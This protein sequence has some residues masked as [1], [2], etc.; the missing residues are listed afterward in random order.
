[1]QYFLAVVV[2]IT[3]LAASVRDLEAG[4]RWVTLVIQVLAINQFS[5]D[6]MPAN[7]PLYLLR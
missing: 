1:M 4:V 6:K 3:D 7:L 5:A 2:V